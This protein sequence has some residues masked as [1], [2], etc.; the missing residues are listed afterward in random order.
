MSLSRRN[1]V[2]CRRGQKRGA[3]VIEHN[4]ALELKQRPDSPWDLITEA[5]IINVEHVVN[6]AGLWAKQV[7]R[8]VGLDLPVSPLEH[9]Y[10]ITETIPEIAA[11]KIELPMVVDLEGFTYMRQDQKGM[12][13]GIYETR[14]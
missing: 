4:R 14:P 9:H 13:I 2:L 1:L 7:G 3:T 5:G 6:A 12:L 11:L 8:M 10:L